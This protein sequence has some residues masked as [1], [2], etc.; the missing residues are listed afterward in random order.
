MFPHCP[1]N[2]LSR[3]L[4]AHMQGCL[5]FPEQRPWI[6][7]SVLHQRRIVSFPDLTSFRAVKVDGERDAQSLHHP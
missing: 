4:P 2:A 6:Q 7:K 3:Y 1:F 5:L